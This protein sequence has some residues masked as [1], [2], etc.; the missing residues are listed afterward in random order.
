MADSLFVNLKF[1][2]TLKDKNDLT[3]MWQ[4]NEAPWA[5]WNKGTK[6]V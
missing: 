2:I 3:Y 1:L 4:N 5:I 6:T